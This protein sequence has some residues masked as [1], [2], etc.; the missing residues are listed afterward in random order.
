M[1]YRQKCKRNGEWIYYKELGNAAIYAQ[2][3]N[4]NFGYPCYMSENDDWLKIVPAKPYKYC[5]SCGLKMHLYDKKMVYL[6]DENRIIIKYRDYE[7]GFGGDKWH[8]MEE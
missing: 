4:C 6:I 8:D 2:C 1:N 7:N 5:P 3:L